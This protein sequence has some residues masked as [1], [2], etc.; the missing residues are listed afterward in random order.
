MKVRYANAEK[1]ARTSNDP[2]LFYPALNRMAAE[3]IVDCARPG[4]RGFDS[5]HAVRRT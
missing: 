3:L 4:W 5:G 1:L 2:R